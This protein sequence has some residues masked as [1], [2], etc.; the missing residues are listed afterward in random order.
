MSHTASIDSSASAE[1]TAED[2]LNVSKNALSLNA[3]QI[4]QVA[5]VLES[6]LSGSSVGLALGKMSINIVSN[7][8]DAPSNL[9]AP[10]SNR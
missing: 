4:Q 9:L 1:A 5:S 2:L 10:S 3:T 7:L 6:L 8:L